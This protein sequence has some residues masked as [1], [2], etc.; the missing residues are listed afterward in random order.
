MTKIESR[1]SKRKIWEYFFFIDCDGHLTDRRVAQA[2][3]E[4]EQSGFK[5]DYASIRDADDL[6]GDGQ[7]RR[8][9]TDAADSEIDQRCT[10]E[11]TQQNKTRTRPS[12][13]KC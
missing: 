10:C 9:F 8:S 7:W 2:I 4:L 3:A 13:G 6:Q 11:Q 12:V 1:P 5:T